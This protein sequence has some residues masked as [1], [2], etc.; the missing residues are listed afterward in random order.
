MQGNLIYILPDD[1]DYDDADG[2][3]PQRSKHAGVFIVFD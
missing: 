1:D 2:V 3:M